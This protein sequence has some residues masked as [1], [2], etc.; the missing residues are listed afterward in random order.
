MY[1]KIA[2]KMGN[3]MR[4]NLG[5]FECLKG[6]KKDSGSRTNMAKWKEYNYLLIDCSKRG[7]RANITGRKRQ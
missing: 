4:F 7:S 1:Q 6:T 3:K 5:A 2:V